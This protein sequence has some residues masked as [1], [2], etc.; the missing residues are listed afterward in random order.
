[1]KKI[2]Q[3][4]LDLQ[5]RRVWFVPPKVTVVPVARN[6]PPLLKLPLTV[7]SCPTFVGLL[8]VKF[9]VAPIVTLPTMALVVT[10]SFAAHKK[11]GSRRIRVSDEVNFFIVV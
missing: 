4:R 5:H 2:I 11:A 8:N 10:V 1:M 7:N 3:C 6:V 9:D